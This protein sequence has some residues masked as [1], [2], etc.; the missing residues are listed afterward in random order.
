MGNDLSVDTAT[1]SIK[2]IKT[3]SKSPN[4][5]DFKFNIKIWEFQKKNSKSVNF[6]KF[7]R[8]S[9]SCS[10]IVLALSKK[11]TNHET[12]PRDENDL[13]ELSRGS[14]SLFEVCHDATTNLTPRGLTTPFTESKKFEGNNFEIYLWNGKLSSPITQAACLS[15]CYELENFLEEDKIPQIM[16]MG[17]PVSLMTFFKND[18]ENASS[19][20]SPS[21]YRDLCKECMLVDSILQQKSSL[22][23]ISFKI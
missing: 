20:Y 1:L 8:F 11:K 12:S 3:T 22:G 21:L 9:E 6:D 7:T 5:K 23:K 13:S 19:L 17:A 4:T 14:K 16:S 18:V 15:T 2:D 10:Y